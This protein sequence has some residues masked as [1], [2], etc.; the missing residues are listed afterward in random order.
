MEYR[1]PFEFS[2][3][4]EYKEHVRTTEARTLNEE[5]VKSQEELTLANFLV[6]NTIAYDYER[7]YKFPTATGQHR[8]YQPDFYLPDYDIYIE[9]FAVDEHDRPPA[10]W[11]GYAEGMN[12]K[13]NLHR[14]METRLVETYS[15]ERSKGVLLQNLERKLKNLRVEFN[16]VPTEELIEKL[17]QFRVRRLA[18]LFGTFL[19]HANSGNMTAAE[20]SLAAQS[21][22]DGSR[23]N[24]FLRIFT[25]VR[26]R[27]QELLSAEGTKDF[28][29]LINEA[30]GHIQGRRWTNS[31]RYVLID[32]FQDISKGRMN[33]AK[34]LKQ[35]ELAY[36]LVGDDWQSIYRFA[37]SSVGLLHQCDQHPG[38]TQRVNLTQTFRFGN[39]IAT[40]STGFIQQNPEQTKRELITGGDAEDHGITV[41]AHENAAEGVKQA[42]QEINAVRESADETVKVLGRYR[43]N[44]G[45]VREQTAAGRTNMEYSTIHRTKG[46]EADH[47]VVVDLKDDRAYGFPSQIQDD[48]LLTIVMPPIHGDPYP[49]A[50][51]RRL[52]YV[53]L[54][55]ARKGAYLITDPKQ[56]SVFVRELTRD[57]PEISQLGVI[58][59][60]CPSCSTGSLIP[61]QS[62][63]NLRCTNYPV[64]RHMWPRCPGCNRGY[65]GIE[66]GS[67]T[68]VCT[69][70]GCGAPAEPCPSCH[71]G[72]LTLKRA[73]NGEFWGC[74]R[75]WDDPPCR[76]SRDPVGP[77]Q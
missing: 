71:R 35:P 56:P 3:E 47:V 73:R 38:H 10:G 17:S 50:E 6:S 58:T 23:T 25:E 52:F 68:P 72:V 65:A 8:Q 28:H 24:R 70:A 42:L 40:P 18:G 45:A 59:P 75:Y 7:P 37:G 32:E 49:F 63:S 61:S 62:N 36:F 44:V 69:N 64:C 29:D 11:T 57:Y 5:V 66:E 54:T 2:T 31:F 22:N 33:L 41:I 55:R 30:A 12:W 74:S 39:R 46:L 43:R 4:K 15:W 27:Y 14:R 26:G 60:K 20:I 51:E 48:P 13:R 21:Q 53:T 34:A 76:F 16:P 19:N 77:Q 9:H 1:A 67:T